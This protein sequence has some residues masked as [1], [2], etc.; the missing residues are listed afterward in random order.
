MGLYADRIQETT[1]TVGT[2]TLT[3]AG[4]VAGYRA[5]SAGFVTGE[6]V[7]YAM[8]DG[9]N[10]EVGDG[11]YTLTGTTLSRDNVYASSNAN[12]LVNFNA[13]A[14][15]VWCDYPAQAVADIGLALAFRSLAI[16][17]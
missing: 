10:W 9:T 5:F 3:L 6:R 7:R 11:T 13:G 2:G 17:R 1:A 8:S 15:Q 16:P 12:A 14:K 4:A